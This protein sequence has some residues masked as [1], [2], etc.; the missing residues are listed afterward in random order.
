MRRWARLQRLH[1]L[2]ARTKTN[3]VVQTFRVIR[4]VRLI[5]LR[6]QRLTA[7][8]P[9]EPSSRTVCVQRRLT[10]CVPDG[11]IG[12]LRLGQEGSDVRSDGKYKSIL[13]FP[14]G[15]FDSTL[16]CQPHCQ[17][18]LWPSNGRR[19]LRMSFTIDPSLDF[20]QSRCDYAHQTNRCSFILF[21]S[22]SGPHL[23]CFWIS[24]G[25]PSGSHSNRLG[26]TFASP[27]T[28]FC[29]TFWIIFESSHK[30]SPKSSPNP[31]WIVSNR[32]LAPNPPVA[33]TRCTVYR[34]SSFLWARSSWPNSW[35]ARCSAS[36]R[37]TCMRSWSRWSR[38]TAFC[39]PS[40]GR[41]TR[42]TRRSQRNRPRRWISRWSSIADRPSSAYTILRMRLA[43]PNATTITQVQRLMMHRTV[44][45]RWALS[46]SIHCS[47]LFI[48]LYSRLEFQVTNQICLYNLEWEILG[49][50]VICD[51]V[52]TL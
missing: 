17:R 30:S 51:R 13:I 12:E 5:Q 2:S 33:P 8:Y 11:E 20:N 3:R 29:I 48:S 26:I 43:A 49:S 25:S 50:Y 6:V 39:S 40:A 41:P 27:L 18:H 15:D 46:H 16:I 42:K 52:C 38:F 47:V 19:A 4:T 45:L 36:I 23:D 24:S 22:V 7:I 37:R 10:D 34:W 35:S 31:F 9:C 44:W 1:S 14:I 32:F 21:A 28:R